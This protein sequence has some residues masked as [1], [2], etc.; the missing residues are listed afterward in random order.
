MS[1]IENDDVVRTSTGI[2]ASIGK[3]FNSGDRYENVKQFYI[4][5]LSQEGWQFVGEEQLYQ[6]ETELHF[7]KGE[8]SVVITYVGNNSRY[9]YQYGIDVAWHNP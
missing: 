6:G 1:Q 5:K 8:Y 4:E 9:T 2:Q 7:R 3:H